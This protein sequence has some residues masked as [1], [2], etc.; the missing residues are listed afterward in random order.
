ME[1]Q[2]SVPGGT[3]G[4]ESSTNGNGSAGSTSVGGTGGTNAGGVG[5][6][7]NRDPRQ[8]ASS[9]GAPPVPRQPYSQLFPQP[10][11]GQSQG[12][13]FT[14]QNRVNPTNF[15]T[16]NDQWGWGQPGANWPGFAIPQ[17]MPA[18]PSMF[19]NAPWLDYGNF[20]GRPSGNGRVERPG[21][22]SGGRRSPESQAGFG[23]F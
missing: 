7:N 19:F 3:G 23:Y 16:N 9:L 21:R 1:S 13:Q 12:N 8:G 10:P 15:V 4:K 20:Y 22:S 6:N 2:Q 18:M 5:R 17:N 14:W 11:D